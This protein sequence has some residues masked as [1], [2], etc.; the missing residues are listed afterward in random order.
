MKD[1]E[2]FTHVIDILDKY[3]VDINDTEYILDY[4]IKQDD[5]YLELVRKF[6]KLREEL[7]FSSNILEH[8]TNN[9]SLTKLENDFLNSL[10]GGNHGKK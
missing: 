4:I 3:N 5:K 8:I 1:V 9:Q 7:A 6:F 10:K 2:E